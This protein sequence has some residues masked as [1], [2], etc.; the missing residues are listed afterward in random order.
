MADRVSDDIP[1][2]EIRRMELRSGPELGR[3]EAFEQW[4]AGMI[5]TYFPLA[6]APLPAPDFHGRISHG[7]YGDLDVTGI[8]ASPQQ[9]RLTDGL[10]AAAD[11]EYLLASVCVR[12]RGRL[13]L[14]DR[15]AEIRPGEMVFFGSSR[16]LLWEFDAAW[17]KTVLQVPVASLRERTGLTLD[18]VPLAVTL[19][20][21]GAAAVVS[22]FFRELVGLQER[23]PGAAAL[24]GEPALD[25]L[26][27]AVLLAGGR[28]P[29]RVSADALLRERVL[30]FMRDH[31]ADPA[32]S[33][34][35]IAQG[36]MIS[37]R[38]LYRIFDEFPDGPAAV[39]RRMR[40]ER[41]CDLLANTDL[42]VPAI[43]AAAGFTGERQ[44][45]RAFRTEMGTTPAA[46]R[47]GG[48]APR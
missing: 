18:D 17:E 13:H 34:D 23:A 38:A 46:F 26:G 28:R 10:I 14:G 33:V 6:V 12:G 40:V 45:Y 11:D 2:P 19:P 32:L 25:L 30:S 21:A 44:F 15:T 36:C 22:R 39:L 29:G 31:R 5:D 41:A 37:R 4:E 20:N 1:A 47:T 9:V 42:S 24:I 35:R 16:K 48:R 3:T 7:R 43:V 8:G 27:S